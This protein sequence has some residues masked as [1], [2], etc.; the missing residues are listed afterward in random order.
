M[1]EEIIERLVTSPVDS[2]LSP[3]PQ[4]LVHTCM[5]HA[6]QLLGFWHY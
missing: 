1:L 4:C 2:P 3:L 5:L 6:L